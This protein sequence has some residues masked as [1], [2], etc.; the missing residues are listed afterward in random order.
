MFRVIRVI[1]LL[2]LSPSFAFQRQ[3]LVLATTVLSLIFV[4]AGLYQIT[5]GML[6]SINHYNEIEIIIC[7]YYSSFFS[8]F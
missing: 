6:S 7:L 3:V 8:S 2:S 1:R 5:E 4:T